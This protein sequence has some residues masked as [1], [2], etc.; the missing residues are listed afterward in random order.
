[1][2]S[3]LGD[4]E[5][6][7]TWSVSVPFAELEAADGQPAD[8]PFAAFA[9]DL[10]RWGMAKI[11]GGRIILTAAVALELRRHHGDR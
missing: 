3:P 9:Q 5:Q 7:S 1:M 10:V 11:V 8:G 4:P 2:P 6:A